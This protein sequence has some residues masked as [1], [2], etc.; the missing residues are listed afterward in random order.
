MAAY[1]DARPYCS[2]LS[3]TATVAEFIES[4]RQSLDGTGR[5]LIGL[6]CEENDVPPDQL[7]AMLSEPVARFN[8]LELTSDRPSRVVED[9]LLHAR[10][11]LSQS[12]EL[13]QDASEKFSSGNGVEAMTAL[14]ACI[15]SWGQVHEAIVKGG[16]LMRIDFEKLQIGNR[17]V[18][19][20]LA[21][22]VERLRDIKNAV[23]SNDLVLLADM[24]KYELDESL[25]EWEGFVDGLIEYVRQSATAP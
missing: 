15:Q 25:Q 18:Q 8:R 10:T 13:V 14:I 4:A 17:S 16:Q 5:L 1:L 12:F 9:I 21:G 22:L 11:C 7:D 2:G 20:W 6:R 19:A 23:E 3:S 24:M